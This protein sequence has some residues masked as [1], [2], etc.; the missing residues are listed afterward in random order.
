MDYAT[1]LTAGVFTELHPV[2]AFFHPKSCVDLS[3]LCILLNGTN[4]GAAR[5]PE[6]SPP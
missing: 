5:E 1:K 4:L 2:V 6:A 3:E